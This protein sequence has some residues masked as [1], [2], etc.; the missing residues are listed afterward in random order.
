MAHAKAQG[1]PIDGVEIPAP[2]NKQGKVGYAIG[3]IKQG[4][5]QANAAKFL[6]YLASNDA[7]DIYAKYGF[8]KATADDLKMRDK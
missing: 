3:T 1:R 6:A 2:L 5:N 8:I 7:Q 4:K